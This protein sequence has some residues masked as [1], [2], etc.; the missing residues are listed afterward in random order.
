MKY[1]IR[2][3]IGVAIFFLPLIGNAAILCGAG[4]IKNLT[5][6]YL[7]M[8]QTR[9]LLDAT[10]GS[11]MMRLNYAIPSP[12]R[13]DGLSR[14]LRAAFLSGK[15]V[16]IFAVARNDCNYIDEIHICNVANECK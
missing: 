1:F 2:K 14:T 4:T 8:D 11:N 3:Y 9:I 5:E 13:F 12:Y 6:G 15:P 16:R 10:E 7:G